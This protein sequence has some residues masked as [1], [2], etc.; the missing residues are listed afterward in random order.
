MQDAK[1]ED[2]HGKKPAG[3]KPPPPPPAM[4]KKPFDKP[5]RQTT[6]RRNKKNKKVRGLLPLLFQRMPQLMNLVDD[7]SCV[8]S[9]VNHLSSRK[10]FKSLAAVK[11]PDEGGKPSAAVMKTTTSELEGRVEDA[12]TKSAE[13]EESAAVEVEAVVTDEASMETSSTEVPPTTVD[14][15]TQTEPVKVPHLV[16]RKMKIKTEDLIALDKLAFKRRKNMQIRE[17]Q[18]VHGPNG[19]AT[20]AKNRCVKEPIKHATKKD[21]T[22]EQTALVLREASVHPHA[23]LSKKTGFFCPAKRQKM[24]IE[25][26][27]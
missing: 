15:H 25:A 9:L 5:A 19:A 1:A 8:D 23:R 13:L 2:P 14:S 10:P 22:P 6:T 18:D 27:F 7:P 21:S 24:H 20:R 12:T 17:G 4:A 26:T 11:A 3:R 16:P